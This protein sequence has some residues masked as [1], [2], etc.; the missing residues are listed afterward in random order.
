VHPEFAG[1]RILV[2]SGAGLKKMP[3]SSSGNSGTDK[4][5]AL[6]VREMNVAEKKA[7]D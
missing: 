4:L 6:R 5:A 1:I 3:L 2:A 7:C